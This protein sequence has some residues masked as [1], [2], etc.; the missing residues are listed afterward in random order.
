M[1]LNL[2][3]LS[4]R[5]APA[6]VGPS[7]ED[8][9]DIPATTA[10]NPVLPPDVIVVDAPPAAPPG[11]NSLSVDPWS[12]VTESN[13]SS[14]ASGFVVLPPIVVDVPDGAAWN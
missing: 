12:S 2:E 10:P 11:D 3:C 1:K 9:L 4:D 14:D 7:P 8:P 6:G 5:L 13:S